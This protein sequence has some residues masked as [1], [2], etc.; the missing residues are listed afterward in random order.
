MT[1]SKFDDVRE[2]VKIKFKSAQRWITYALRLSVNFVL[3]VGGVYALNS[4]PE[5]VVT[6]IGAVLTGVMGVCLIVG[7]AFSFFGWGAGIWYFEQIGSV[8]GAAGA[9]IYFWSVLFTPEILVLGGG[10][11]VS[12]T[13]ALAL[14]LILRVFE[15]ERYTSII[16]RRAARMVLVPR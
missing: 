14:M 8:I 13:L 16:V 15:I 5:T 11:R 4:P 12:L 9:I 10:L 6:S 2:H 3:V 1:R 7:G